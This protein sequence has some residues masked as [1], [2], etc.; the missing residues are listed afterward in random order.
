MQKN[1]ADVCLKDSEI[2]DKQAIIQMETGYLKYIGAQGSIKYEVK[3]IVN[4]E[5]IKGDQRS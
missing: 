2:M 3:T 4:E 1:L 5:V